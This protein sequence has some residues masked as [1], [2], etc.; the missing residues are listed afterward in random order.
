LPAGSTAG[1][2]DAGVTDLRHERGAVPEVA[3]VL[4]LAGTGSPM[5]FNGMVRHYYLRREPHRGDLRVNL[6]PKQDRSAQCHAIVLRV[7]NGLE[8][9]AKK[10]N[11]RLKIVE[12]PPGP[13]VLS[14]LVAEVYSKPQHNYAQ[15]RADSRHVRNL[16]EQEPGV[17]EVDDTDEAER[18][19]YVFRV[20]K[21]KASLTGITTEQIANTLR[22]ALN[23]MPRGEGDPEDVRAGSSHLPRELNPL[24]ILMQ[25]P[26][27]DRSRLTQLERLGVKTPT[28]EIVRIAELGRFEELPAEQTIYHKNLRRV[29]YVTAETAGRTPGEAVIGLIFKLR[30]SPTPGGSEVVWT[31]EGEWKITLDV[32]RDLG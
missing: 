31:G 32:F 23:G 26:H 27:T 5:D 21:E 30:D 9:I 3:A 19:R 18:L 4:S 16:F 24:V 17:V 13:P 1:A 15:L 2:A 12:I 28:G 10:H 20:D 14:T 29:G 25:L 11:A 8:A 22:I 6:I 7:R